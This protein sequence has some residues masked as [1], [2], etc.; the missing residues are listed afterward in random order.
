ME[1]IEYPDRELL[2][3]GLADRLASAL[4][5]SLLVHEHASF[6]VPGGASPGETF[7]ALSGVELDWAR[8][9]VF[10]G[11]ERWV[12]EDDPRSNTGLLRRTLLTDRAARAVL[13]PLVT[14]APGPEAGAAE[15][16]PAFAGEL[17]ISLLLLGM[18]EDGHT[19]SL[20]PGAPGLAEAMA[21]GAPVLAA[22]R[23][24]GQEPRITFTRPVL[25]D[26]IETHL[27]IMGEGKRRT[28]EAARRA[29]PMEMPVAAF[30]RD[31]TVH[32]AP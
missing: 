5:N 11:D 30:L 7:G 16:A 15:L 6:C 9:H 24:E 14:G 22:V 3:M 28:L 19:A 18:G 1:L 2:A 12:P 26:A 29:D 20:F 10:P 32:W 4:K 8:V 25:Q 31:A 23:P 21:H 17:P 13:V 27:L